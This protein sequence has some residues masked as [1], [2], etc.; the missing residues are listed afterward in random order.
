MGEKIQI[1][2]DV[3]SFVDEY[4]AD[5]TDYVT[6]ED[7]GVVEMTVTVKSDEPV[8]VEEYETLNHYK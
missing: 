4:W 7:E 2:H 3:S 6:E 1:P 8:V 5:I